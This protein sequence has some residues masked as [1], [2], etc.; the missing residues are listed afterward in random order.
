MP[1]SINRLLRLERLAALAALT[2]VAGCGGGRGLEGSPGLSPVDDPRA[3][4]QPRAQ[5]PDRGVRDR[6]PPD[7]DAL[8]PGAPPVG[9]GPRGTSQAT[10]GERR[11]D[12]VGYAS[13]YGEEMGSGRTASGQ[14]FDPRAITAA[15]SSLP[16]GSFVEVTSLDSGKTILVLIND[17]GPVSQDR[18]LDLSRGAAQL[19]GVDRAGIAAVRV[20]QVDPP[21]PDQ[22]ALR[23]GRSASPRID[24][25]AVLLSALRKRLPG[26]RAAIT[27]AARPPIRAGASYATPARAPATAAGSGFYVQ[28]A[29][30]S[31]RDRAQSLARSVGGSVLSAGSIYRVRLGPFP[32][33]ASA[34]RARDQAARGGYEDA[35]VIAEE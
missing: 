4:D 34:A 14:P 22:T 19:L 24:T 32:D 3:I 28:L 9:T 6:F 20:R 35:R 23:E 7:A 16:M 27:P 31:N 17:R 26:R 8:P 2:L 30:I 18:V 33:R 29:A 10:P 15:H 11:Y 13:W 1:S 21:G 12:A 5:P 25:P